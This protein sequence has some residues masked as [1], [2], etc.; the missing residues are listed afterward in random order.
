MNWLQRHWDA[1]AAANFMLGGAGSGLMVA[2]LF[3]DDPSVP[4]ILSLVLVAS[5]LTA[6]WLEIG[7]K[8]RAV[9]VFFN[10]FTSWMTR[11]SFAALL[12]FPLGIGALYVPPAL[13][14]AAAAAATFLYCQARILRASKGI[15]AWRA[16]QVVPLIVLTGLAEGAGIALVFSVNEF[17][18]FLFALAV[19]ARVIAWWRYRA[20]VRTSAL[21]PAGKTLVW[22]GTLAALVLVFVPPLAGLAALAA[23]GWLK[24]VLVTRASFNQG[25]SLPHLP[26]RGSR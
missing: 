2:A 9:H 25:F 1:R 3:V 17:L 18:L 15:P 24:F 12:L 22:I 19:I 13:P 5:G 7:R 23:G 8:L 6:V 10:P 14:F 21:E 26:V 16:P 20:A 4:V 11:E